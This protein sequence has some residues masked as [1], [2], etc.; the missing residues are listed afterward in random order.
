[1]RRFRHIVVGGGMTAAAAVRGIRERDPQ[2]TIA[3]VGTETHPPYNRPPL[4]KALWKGD[5]ETTVWRPDDTA[6]AELVLGRRIT[7]IDAAARRLTDDRGETYEYERLLLATGGAPRR[8]PPPAADAIVYFRTL[9]DYRRLRA[10]ADAKR[11]FAVIGG[12]FIGSEIAAALR[13]QGCEV[14][15]VIPEA[16]LGARVFPAELAAHLA[17]FYRG[18]GVDV[19]TGE[20]VSGVAARKSALTIA[21][22]TNRELA[23]D[24]VVAGLGIVP[25]VELAQQAGLAVD[26]GIVVDERLRAGRPEIFAAGDVANFPSAALGH[27]VR[28]EHE[29][30]ANA[31]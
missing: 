4:S 23:A 19:R 28:V 11:R 20:G 14:A 27:R 2:G 16:G 6:G 18:K 1:M 25:S 17:E 15:M 31:Q 8:L 3:L 30:N 7:S 12:G 29:D 24:V 26:N 5:A 13:M 10:A 21:T 9:D 22:T